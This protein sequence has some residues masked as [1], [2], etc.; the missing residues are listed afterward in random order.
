M[1]GARWRFVGEVGGVPRPQTRI[2]LAGGLALEGP[3]GSVPEEAFPGRQG[4]LCFARLAAQHGRPVAVDELANELWLGELPAAWETALRAIVSKLRTL[5][6]RSGVHDAEIVA[7]SGA[8]RL[9][10]P[11][12][13]WLDIDAA[14]DA[15]HR[16][17]TAAGRG[18]PD[19][20]A[21]WALGA[22][23]IAARPLLPGLESPW[24]ERQRE[25]LTDILLR[26]LTCLAEIWLAKGDVAL[27]VRDAELAIDLDPYRESS[28]RLAIRAHLAA[29]DQAAAVRAY[30]RC[31]QLLRADLGIEPSSETTALV[32]GMLARP[33][34]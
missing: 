15:I 1:G 7:V 32:A 34:S 2:Y 4:R 21:G 13:A 22:R 29:G 20:A 11:A 16:A 25:R 24:L 5:L 27:A 31:R 28:R 19:S 9:D 18:E 8:Y 23:A 10:L 14:A 6:A 3:D 12:D 30:E 26:A 33:G 17:E